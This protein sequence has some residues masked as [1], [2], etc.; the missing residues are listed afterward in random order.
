MYKEH[1]V[2]RKDKN[3]EC[4]LTN[5]RF[6]D[7]LALQDGSPWQWLY[8]FVS[9]CILAG[10]PSFSQI[11]ALVEAFWGCENEGVLLT[12]WWHMLPQND[13]SWGGR[14]R[15]ITERTADLFFVIGFSEL[16]F[17]HH[18]WIKGMSRHA[19]KQASS[20]FDEK[21][22][23]SLNDAWQVSWLAW[24]GIEFWWSIDSIQPVIAWLPKSILQN[25]VWVAFLKISA[26][27][28][29]FFWQESTA[30]IGGFHSLFQVNQEKSSKENE[31]NRMLPTSF[32]CLEAETMKL[33]RGDICRNHHSHVKVRGGLTLP[34][35]PSNENVM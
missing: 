29:V 26:F 9:D 27:V 16:T 23:I 12:C 11:D 10:C 7:C 33:G 35:S 15:I 21:A 30:I 28:L 22:G 20:I 32:F 4:S 18:N 25:Q 1:M 8:E 2:D 31:W 3:A 24:G 34:Q 6:C 14:M 5:C 17:S 13:S 19:Y